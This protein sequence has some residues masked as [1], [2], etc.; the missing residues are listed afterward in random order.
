MVATARGDSDA[1]ARLVQRHQQLAWRIAYNYVG[2]RTEAE[3]LVQSA[4][5]RI[6]GNAGGYQPTA[7]FTSFLR[8]VLSRLCID[9][10]ERAAPVYVPEMPSVGDPAPSASERIVARERALTVQAAL[11]RLPAT[12]RLAVVLRY[13]EELGYADIAAALDVTPK[14]V[15]RLLD[16]ARK[17]LSTALA[18]MFD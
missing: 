7:R 6:F 12:Q 2:D 8:C 11:G 9:W 10:T 3:D 16:R 15:E 1:F 14:A 17:S 4:F 13:Y 5:L 18:A